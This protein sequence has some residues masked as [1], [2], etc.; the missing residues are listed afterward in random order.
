MLTPTEG[1]IE[2][3]TDSKWSKIWPSIISEFNL[4]DNRKLNFITWTYD[5]QQKIV[6]GKVQI[7]W[8]LVVFMRTLSTDNCSLTTF[9]DDMSKS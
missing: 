7:D 9:S 1:Q 6:N 2:M 4:E 8:K 5:I 3:A